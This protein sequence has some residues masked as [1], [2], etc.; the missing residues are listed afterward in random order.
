MSLTSLLKSPSPL[1][2]FFADG[3]PNTRELVSS[4]NTKLATN[5]PNISDTLS[6][7]DVSIIG[8]AFDYRARIYFQPLDLERVVARRGIR[9]VQAHLS[10]KARGKLADDVFA[11]VDAAKEEEILR[12]LREAASGRTILMMTHRL[13]AAR[14]ADRIIVLTGGRV[15]EAGTHDELVARGGVYARLWRI[16]QLEEEIARAS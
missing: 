3:F 16:Q 4:L 11:N 9:M 6:S 12:T 2:E 13:R 5:A 14:A 10:R 8:T 7:A 15:E 1:R